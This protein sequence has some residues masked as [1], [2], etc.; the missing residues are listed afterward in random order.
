PRKF[1]QSKIPLIPL[2]FFVY[3]ISGKACHLRSVLA[4]VL[5]ILVGAAL[6]AMKCPSRPRPLLWITWSG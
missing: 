2:S 3:G 4:S 1:V 5:T 6:A